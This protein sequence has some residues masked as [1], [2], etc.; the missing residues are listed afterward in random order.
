M[1]LVQGLARPGFYTVFILLRRVNRDTSTA[2]IL[3]DK[4]P[5]L[6]AID[7]REE[8]VDADTVFFLAAPPD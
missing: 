3:I 2:R 5:Y 6:V 8:P 1:H 4:S 7:L